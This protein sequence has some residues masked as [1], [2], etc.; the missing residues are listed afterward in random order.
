MSQRMIL[1]NGVIY[2]PVHG[3]DGRLGTL[4]IHAGT[5]VEA[6]DQQDADKIIDLHQMIVM[7]GGVDIHCHI[8]G[9]S[10]N[11]ARRLLPE[12]VHRGELLN[13][14]IV[15]G[16]RYA[17]LGYTTAIEAAVAATA[18]RQA[19]FELQSTPNLD[20]GI[21]L[22]LANHEL[23][24]ETLA[25]SDP[26]C[27]RDLVSTMLHRT[28]A[29]GIKIVN[30]GCVAHWQRH[31]GNPL[32]VK[33][34]DDLI[35][36]STLTPRSI[37]TQLATV[38]DDL[39]LPH[40]VHVHAN[41]LGVPGNIDIT[42]QTLHALQGHRHHLTHAQFH[43]YG[44]DQGKISSAAQQLMEFI[45]THT[46]TTC[47]IGQV[48]FGPAVTLTEDS[49]LEY[50]L[51]QLTGQR[52]VNLDL[53]L[54]SGCG[55]LPFEFKDRTHLHAM[56]WAIGLELFLLSTDPWRVVL[57]TDHPN[58]ASFLAYPKIIA[59]LMDASLRHDELKRLPEAVRERSLLRELHREY[60][61]GEIAIITRAGP[62]RILGLNR[63]GHLGTGADAD[64]TVYAMH[65]NKEAMFSS[66]RFVFK[67]GQLLVEDGHLRNNLPGTTMKCHTMPDT[68]AEKI[69]RQW[70]VE[71]GSYAY[72]QFGVTPR[73]QEMLQPIPGCTRT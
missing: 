16:Q 8:A 21:L 58:G 27:L 41:R 33:S 36:S 24:L 67:A 44:S 32:S 15:T 49:P 56:Q 18:A 59:L 65:E 1:R 6:F 61:L 48:M 10:V 63:K 60:S 37:L 38:A 9:P 50:L 68:S 73:H 51:W 69:L 17:A 3:V 19:H 64:I 12:F 4:Y 57:S 42:L 55:M 14:T 54:E 72:E 40:P 43:A 31:G 70:F 35:G 62:A 71:K 23:I 26:S 22:L 2:D 5:I 20:K 45:N 46:E 30:P 39:Q 47:D 28:G 13:S 34:I 52:W 25:H 53:E 29:Y 11:R 66:P 7:P